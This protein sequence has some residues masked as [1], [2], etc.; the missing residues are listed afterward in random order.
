MKVERITAG[1]ADLLKRFLDGCGESLESFRYFSKR[2]LTIIQ[3]HLV[4]L[5]AFDDDGE[6]VAYGH[7]DPEGGKVWLG[8]CVSSRNRGKGYGRRMMQALLDEAARLRIPSIC[9]TVDRDNRTAIRMYEKSG[10][11]RVEES[12]TIL[13][14]RLDFPADGMG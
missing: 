6:P 11:K 9:L 8:V 2:P 3:N 4:T 5:L 13:R 12:D 14:Y 10:F 7:L 1:Q